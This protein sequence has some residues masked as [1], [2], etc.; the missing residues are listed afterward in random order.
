MK[1]RD[2][3]ICPHLKGSTEGS[4]CGVVNSL[5]KD[6]EGF[7]VKLCMSRRHEACSMYK[8]SLQNMIECGCYSISM[9]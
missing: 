7:T 1:T 3:S 4:I 2:Y 5:I 6:M 8:R 9:Q